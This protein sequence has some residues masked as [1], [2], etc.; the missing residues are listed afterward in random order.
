MG[1]WG[2]EFGKW[3]VSASEARRRSNYVEPTEVSYPQVRQAPRV[4]YSGIL[5]KLTSQFSGQYAEAR[6]ANEQ[7]YGEAKNIYEQII[8]LF[9]PGGEFGKGFEAQIGRAKTKSVA[10][11]TQAL[12]SSG[13]YGT[14]QTA[15][16]AKKFEE[17]VG[18]PA[19][20]QMEDVRISKYAG[21]MGAKAGMIERREDE[22][23]DYSMIMNLMRQVSG[24]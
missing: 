10:Q 5:N 7:R 1:T 4:N 17:E 23:P 16:L 13:L 9:S 8:G 20:L 18:M 2:E 3:G 24:G 22:Y 6:A 19:R 15:G 12:V 14:T 21:A 11:G